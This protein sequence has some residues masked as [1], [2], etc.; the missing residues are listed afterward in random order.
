MALNL[1]DT[2]LQIDRMADEVSARQSDFDERLKRALGTLD[3]FDTQAYADKLRRSGSGVAWNLPA[4]MEHPSARVAPPQLPADY[5]VVAVDGSHID[6]DRHLAARC[7]LINI[8]VAELAYGTDPDAQLYSRPKLYASDDE[9][10]IRDDSSGREELIQGAVLGAKRAVE[11][12]RALADVAREL[13]PETPTLALLDGTLVMIGIGLLRYGNRQFV[14]RRLVEEGFAQALADLRELAR[15]RPLAVASYIS[16]PN[17]VEVANATR[18][19]HCPYQVAACE[20]NC[21]HLPARE[22]PCDKAV[23]GIRDRQLFANT[24]NEGER[25]AVFAGSYQLVK[26]YYQ[27][28]DVCFFYV[29][30]GVEMGRVEVPSWVAQDEAALGLTHAMIIDQC[31]KG[32]GYPT[33]LM[34]AHEQAVVNGAD[35]RSFVELV[36]NALQDRRLPVYT[37]EKNRTK[38]LRWV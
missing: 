3:G 19:L 5:R 18:L 28:Q 8:G 32:P 31:R 20:T 7:F 16:L 12:V 14:L 17:S 10:A 9:L 30:T 27:G 1:A 37:S 4:P 34:E 33:A 26:S 21:G 11:E 22:R 24:L 36:E 29:N 23:G 6:V 13:P 35:R 2:A 25:S 38:R 15:D